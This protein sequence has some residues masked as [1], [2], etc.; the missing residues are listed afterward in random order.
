M[1]LE[2]RL[3]FEKVI[4]VVSSRFVGNINLDD[5]IDSSLQDLGLLSQANR[6]S[7]FLFKGEK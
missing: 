7:L 1:S 6:V 5:S 2:S 4:S 3:N